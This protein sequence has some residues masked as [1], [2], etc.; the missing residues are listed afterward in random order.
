MIVTDNPN[1]FRRDL[2]KYVPQVFILEW[3]WSD[4]KLKCSKDFRNAV[5]QN[6]PVEQLQAMIDK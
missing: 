2:P 1:Y 4:G 3:S 5:E 6:F